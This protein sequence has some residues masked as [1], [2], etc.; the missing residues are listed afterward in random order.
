MTRSLWPIVLLAA[1][2]EGSNTKADAQKIGAF[3]AKDV[4]QG[5][6]SSQDMWIRLLIKEQAHADYYEGEDVG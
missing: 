6:R 4:S 2:Y 1:G 5:F 3:G